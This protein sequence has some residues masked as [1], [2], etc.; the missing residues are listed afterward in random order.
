MLLNLENDSYKSKAKIIIIE[1]FQLEAVRIF[2]VDP[3]PFTVFSGMNRSEIIGKNP[4]K[5]PAGIL[6]PPTH[7]DYPEPTFSAEVF[8][9]GK[10]IN[11]RGKVSYNMR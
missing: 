1:D 4:E 3:C 10:S 8:N 7:R 2:P 5:F 11:L 9:L 6:L